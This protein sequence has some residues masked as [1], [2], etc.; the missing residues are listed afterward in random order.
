MARQV[1]VKA[2]ALGLQRGKGTRLLD[3][4]QACPRLHL[5]QLLTERVHIL[6]Q[7]AAS[8]SL[9]S[10]QGA[11]VTVGLQT[12][13]INGSVPYLRSQLHGRLVNQALLAVHSRSILETTRIFFGKCTL[14]ESRAIS[15]TKYAEEVARTPLDLLALGQD[16]R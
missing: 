6:G 9:E 4:L 13:P 16:F 5:T 12:G 1:A 7:N 3:S 8:R 10:S 14:V 11:H 15:S 2:P